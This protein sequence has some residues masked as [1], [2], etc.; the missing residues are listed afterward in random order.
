MAKRKRVRNVLLFIFLIQLFSSP[1]MSQPITLVTVGDSLTAGDGDNDG[2]GWPVRLLSMLQT[3][4]PGSTLSNLAISGDTTQDLINKQLDAAVA[5][6]N[7]APAGNEKMA[8]VWIGSNDLFGLYAGDVCPEYYSDLATCEEI[9]MGYAFEN[10]NTILNTLKATGATIHIALLDDQTRRPVIADAALR[11]ETFPDITEA[12]IPRMS[13]QIGLY[14]GQVSAYAAVHGAGVVDFFNTT[15]FENAATLSDDGNHPN[16]PGYDA[17]A[18]IWHQAV[19]GASTA[20]APPLPSIFS[21][22]ALDALTVERNETFT[23]SVSM[24]A[25]DMEN[26]AGDWWVVYI[27]PD[28]AVFTLTSEPRWA[29]GVVPVLSIPLLSFDA[30]PIFSDALASPGLYSFYFIFDN[31]PDG[32]FAAPFWY[33]ALTVQVN[34]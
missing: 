10:V 5:R 17:I 31:N 22:D 13:T 15:I 30:I 6:L 34:E 33:D 23:V 20:S 9:E 26:Q 8:L 24:D 12:E 4:H 18:Q 7:E 28:G 1:A 3:L 25:R 16:G 27:T 11:A 2:G 14:N 32:A 21:G 19:T 29:E